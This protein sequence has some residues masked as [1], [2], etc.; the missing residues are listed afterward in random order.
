MPSCFLDI[1][2]PW[3]LGSFCHCCLPVSPDVSSRTSILW[4][5]LVQPWPC[6]VP[7]IVQGWQQRVI[8][9]HVAA[10]SFWEPPLPWV[11]FFGFQQ[12]PTTR[13]RSPCRFFSAPKDFTEAT[14]LGASGCSDSDSIS[15]EVGF[16]L[17]RYASIIPWQGHRLISPGIHF[18]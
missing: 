14:F 16:L 3:S 7:C 2:T 13:C 5:F 17:S 12:R 18:C 10:N 11:L 15:T 9:L 4:R 1:A 6:F 8:T